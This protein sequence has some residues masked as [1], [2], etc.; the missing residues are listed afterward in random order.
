[1]GCDLGGTGMKSYR[2]EALQQSGLQ[3]EELFL[4]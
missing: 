4:D 1:M 3:L 2:T